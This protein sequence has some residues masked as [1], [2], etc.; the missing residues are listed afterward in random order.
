MRCTW[1]GPSNGSQLQLVGDEGEI[2]EDSL[3]DPMEAQERSRCMFVMNASGG[4]GVPGE[5]AQHVY[6]LVLQAPS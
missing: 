3:V 4:A 5:V 6:S 2:G 1:R